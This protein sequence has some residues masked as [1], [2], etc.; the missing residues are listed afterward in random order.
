[1]SEKS[2]SD[3]EVVIIDC[4]ATVKEDFKLLD[5]NDNKRRRSLRENRYKFKEEQNVKVEEEE[6]EEEENE[7]EDEEVEGVE[8]EEENGIIINGRITLAYKKKVVALAEKHPNW[9][10]STLRRRGAQRLKSYKILALWKKE[11]ENG[12]TKHDKL[13]AIR[14]ECFDRFREA[15]RNG[16]AVTTKMLQKWAIEAAAP[17]LSESFKFQAGEHWARRFKKR[18]KIRQMKIT[19]P[20]NN[21]DMLTL[22]ETEL[23]NDTLPTELVP[24]FDPFN[25]LCI[26][27]S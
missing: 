4:S 13:R 23:S 25:L 11:I 1:M 10:L 3:G 18:H 12:G 22:E 6:E 20:N 8:E 19:N 16:E 27:K 7:N 2:A 21:S 26:P 17:F 14:K 5:H 15:R 24:T 9:S